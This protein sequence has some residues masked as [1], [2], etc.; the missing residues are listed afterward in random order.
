MIPTF[1]QMLNKY[2]GILQKILVSRNVQDNLY[3]KVNHLNGPSAKIISSVTIGRR[4]WTDVRH[5]RQGSFRV[6]PLGAQH[7]RFSFLCGF[8]RR[9][10]GTTILAQLMQSACLQTRIDQLRRGDFW[11]KVANPNFQRMLSVRNCIAFV[12]HFAPTP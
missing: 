1:S 5:Y 7:E 2:L 11:R 3:R 8:R 4:R 6:R 9:N 12:L 10:Y